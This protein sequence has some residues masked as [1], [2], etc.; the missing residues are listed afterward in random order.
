MSSEVVD[1]LINGAKII[2]MDEKRRIYMDGSI[3]IK[4]DQIAG[5]GKRVDIEKK[6]TATN[7]IDG[8]RF[9]ITP[10]FINGHIHITGDPL[11]RNYVPDD[12]YC[13][14]QEKLTKWVMPRYFAHSAEEERVS[15]QL[16]ALEM[17]K[18]GTT[19][20]LEAG[21]IRHLDSVVEGLNET[22]IRGRVGSWVTGRAMNPDEDQ[23]QLNE[24]GI[25]TLENEVKRYPARKGNLI[26]AWPILIGHSTNSDEIWQAAKTIADH[27]GLGISAHMSPYQEDPDWFLKEY[28]RRPIEHLESIGVL[29]DN[30]SLT[31]VAHID[32][33][34]LNILARTGTNVIFC[35]LPALKGAFGVTSVGRYPEMT[36]AGIN[37][38]LGTDGYDIDILH[39]ARIVASLF[40]DIHQD[41]RH[42]PVHETLT[43]LTCNGAK[44]MG[45]QDQI[46]SLEVGKKADFSCHDTD[47]SEW[48]PILSLVSQLIWSADGRGIHSVWV[49][50]IRVIDNYR[51]TMI[52]EKE[53]MGRVQECGESVIRKSKIPFVSPW[54]VIR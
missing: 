25:R 13:S 48:R 27:N 30:V 46:G 6:Y 17:L 29:G 14:P 16:A 11:T 39:S 31:H 18:A 19:C 36:R 40:K 41:V 45:M 51:S 32:E 50:G 20:F 1:T 54:P 4:G 37:M 38:L 10:G 33:N 26:S 9:V 24:E 12:I 3:A 23:N 2:T 8:R 44:A 47:R 35:P 42:Y 15:A 7:N 34:E 53:L 5:I 28:G 43:M 52:D 21:T 22:G 49:D